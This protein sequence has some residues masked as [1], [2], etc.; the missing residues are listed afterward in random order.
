[1]IK[2]ID[3]WQMKDTGKFYKYDGSVMPW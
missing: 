3:Q 2:L 1:M